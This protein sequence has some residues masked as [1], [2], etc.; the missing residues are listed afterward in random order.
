MT[1]EEAAAA[2]DPNLAGLTPLTETFPRWPLPNDRQLSLR[3]RF[4]ATDMAPPI[5]MV[6]S[7]RAVVFRQGDF[8]NP[9]FVADAVSYASGHRDR[10]QIEAGSRLTSVR[11]AMAQIDEEQQAVLSAALALR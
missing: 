4:Y 11:S 8:L 6:S 3:L 2:F 5:E 1:R 9:I 10:N 7:V